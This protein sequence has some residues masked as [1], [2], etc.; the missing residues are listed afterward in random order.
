MNID[1][2][3]QSPVHQWNFVEQT[4]KLK[5]KLIQHETILQQLKEQLNHVDQQLHLVQEQSTLID[6]QVASASHRQS[7]KRRHTFNSLVDISGQVSCSAL[8]KERYSFFHSYSSSSSLHAL[9]LL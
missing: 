5:S 6:H 3:D 1:F 2:I 8:D 9:Q 7:V 4:S